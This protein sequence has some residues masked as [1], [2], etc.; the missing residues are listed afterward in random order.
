MMYLIKIKRTYTKLH[1]ISNNI[2]RMFFNNFSE[3]LF[4][5]RY[6]RRSDKR[7]IRAKAKAKER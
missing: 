4:L 7:Q 5:A 2:R 6:Y 3:K 1:I